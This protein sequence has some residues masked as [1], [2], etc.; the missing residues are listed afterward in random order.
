[1]DYHTEFGHIKSTM[2]IFVKIYSTYISCYTTT[3][4][5]AILWTPLQIIELVFSGVKIMVN[6]TAYKVILSNSVVSTLRQQFGE[7]NFL[8]QDDRAPMPS[9]V[10]KHMVLG[11]W[12]GGT[13]VTCTKP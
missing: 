12:C 4:Y 1:M 8:F 9:Q 7:G 2:K 11:V 5:L 3:L 13:Q 6:G 10:H